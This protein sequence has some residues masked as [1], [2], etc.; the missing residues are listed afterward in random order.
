M[1]IDWSQRAERG[2]V[3]VLTAAA[4]A[5]SAVEV[6]AAEVHWGY[7]G[8]I[9]P[10]HWGDLGFPLCAQGSEQ[11]PIDLSPATSLG[12]SAPSL[13][14]AYGINNLTLL[15][16]GHTVRADVLGSTRSLIL[17][18]TRYNLLQF[19]V[20]WPSEHS[21][22]QALYP[23]EIHLVHRDPLTGELAVVGLFVR[24]G[25]AHAEL[26]KVFRALP[27]TTGATRG[28]SGFD[29]RRMLP[30]NRDFYS[31]DG[32]L[33]TPACDEGVRWS[34]MRA[35]ISMSADQIQRF[36]ALFSGPEFPEGNARPV[37]PRNGRTVLL[38]DGD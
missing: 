10:E 37:Q 28:V 34:V 27:A 7:H 21:V 2:L 25:A 35:S 14:F 32:S 5:L 17:G 11:T 30:S 18:G 6:R 36:R 13:G 9:G 19:H 33:T 3:A 16:N 15:H 23:L 24:S 1:Q 26:E 38:V 20:H 31:Y 4:L 22:E 8:E 12:A 29:L